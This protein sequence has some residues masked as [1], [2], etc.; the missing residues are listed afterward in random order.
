VARTLRLDI[1]SPRNPDDMKG[2]RR[3][4]DIP[5]EAAA[6]LVEVRFAEAKTESWGGVVNDSLPE[7][8]AT[9]AGLYF[10]PQCAGRNTSGFLS[11]GTTDTGFVDIDDLEFF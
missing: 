7:V 10:Q 9:M 5:L 2:V 3:G 4:W 1:N 6:K 8:L 11:E